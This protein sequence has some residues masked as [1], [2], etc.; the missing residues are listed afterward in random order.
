MFNPKISIIVPVYKVEK[1]LHR[2]LDSIVNQTFTDW[3]CIL[4]D[5][6]SPDNSGIICDEYAQMD[7]RFK[8]IHQENK[9]VSAARNAGLDVAKG[10]WIGF[11]DSDDWIEK[12]TYEVAYNKAIKESVDLIQWGYIIENERSSKKVFHPEGSFTN[13]NATTYWVSSMCQK[14]VCR[15][16]I[17]EHDIYF[18]IKI[19]LTE[20]RFVAWRCYLNST[21]SFNIEK[22]YYHY[23]QN[24]SSTTHNV[25]KEM[26][27][28]E[29]TIL[30]ELH[31]YATN[32]GVDIDNY[33]TKFKIDVKK[34]FLTLVTPDFHS[35]RNVFPEINKE[36]RQNSGSITIKMALMGYDKLAHIIL[37]LAKIKDKILCK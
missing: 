16:L 11:V 13:K 15:K 3:E 14:L 30:L 25:T 17:Y 4:I 26:L 12:E 10:E 33:L 5:D 2:C 18:P 32:M 7:R 8:V 36:L 1:Y 28:Q 27:M 23:F 35:C 22:C 9:G 21:K 31:Q 6:G 20:D 24:N 34:E 29:A 37:K 19:K